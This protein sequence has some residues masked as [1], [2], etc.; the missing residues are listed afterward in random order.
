MAP[1][2]KPSISSPLASS[3]PT[4]PSNAQ[5]EHL[6]DIGVVDMMSSPLPPTRMRA[7]AALPSNPDPVAGGPEQ[8]QGMPS[9]LTPKRKRGTAT[10]GESATKRKRDS[11]APAQ[12]KGGAK[13]RTP[14]NT[15]V[16]H[17][18][19]EESERELAPGRLP[20]AIKHKVRAVNNFI[21]NLEGSL[22]PYDEGSSD[23]NIATISEL[24]VLAAI[25]ILRVDYHLA[26]QY[27][28][29]PTI[30]DAGDMVVARLE[31]GKV[32]LDFD[33]TCE[34]ERAAK[35]KLAGRGTG[36]E[37]FNLVEV[38]VEMLVAKKKRM[39]DEGMFG[40]YREAG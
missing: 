27:E 15:A 4:T 6:L 14:P 23:A 18:E 9:T 10:G 16:N 24:D 19:A 21:D 7:G 3:P 35:E 22:V 13:K 29:P 12:R 11:P 32:R 20:T 8:T 40:E 25:K 36:L 28:D 1:N 5:R 39:V 30:D 37:E 31:G 17:E 26:R 33:K 38:E 2:H 34:T